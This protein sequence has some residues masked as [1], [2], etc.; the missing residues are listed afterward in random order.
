MNEQSISPRRPSVF[1]FVQL[2][3]GE[4]VV[5][6]QPY[7]VE[8]VRYP[9]WKFWRNEK[10]KYNLAVLTTRGRFFIIDPDALTVEEKAN[11]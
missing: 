7:R 9:R 2:P 10:I 4:V 3:D 8:S 1:D 11:Q 5:N 6:V